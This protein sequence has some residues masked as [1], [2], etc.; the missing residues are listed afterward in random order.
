MF[1]DLS[2]LVIFHYVLLVL[3]IF[4]MFHYCSLL[5]LLKTKNHLFVLFALFV[6]MFIVCSWIF[7][8]YYFF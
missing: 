5:L 1:H 6:F 2:V 3:I 4:I 8:I 7:F